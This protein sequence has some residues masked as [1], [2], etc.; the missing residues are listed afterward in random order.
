MRLIIF[1][2]AIIMIAGCSEPD[3]SE[4][5]D[6][7][8][9]IYNQFHGK[10]EITR[11]F[12]DRP[13]D[14]NMDG[15]SS[16]DLL[17][18]IPD[19]ERSGLE[20]RIVERSFTGPGSVYLFVQSWSEQNFPHGTSS[21]DT[22]IL[23]DY[24]LQGVVRTFTLNRDKDTLLIKHDENSEINL[25]KFPV[26]G[27]VAVIDDGQIQ[28]TVMKRILTSDGWQTIKIRTKYSRYTMNT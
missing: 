28:V 25:E 11:S 14:I 15:K 26:P 5:N 18:E 17:Q 9:K 3:I 19:L 1:T 13:V 10:Y 7:F 16:V 8:E 27:E 23:P 6:S 24:V 2:F 4:S 21:D 20:L 22:S 12:S